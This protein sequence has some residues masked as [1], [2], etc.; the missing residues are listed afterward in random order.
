[1]QKKYDLDELALIRNTWVDVPEEAIP[2]E[3][4][5]LFRKRKA[6]VNLYIDGATIKEIE[7]ITGIP[8]QN[9]SRMIERCCVL[10]KNNQYLGY[11]SLVPHKRIS[12]SDPENNNAMG[13][14]LKLLN[15]HPELKEYIEGLY[16]GNKK[17]TLERNMNAKT[18]HK[19]F[20][21]KCIQIGIPDYEYPFNTQTKGYI[22]LC[23]YLNSLSSEKV[24]ESSHRLTKDEEQKLNS[25]GIGN[26]Y[27]YPSIAPYSMVQ[28]DGHKIDIEYYVEV[29]EIDGSITK[30]VAMRPWLF[31]VIDVSTRCILGYSVSQ[32]ENY[33]QYDVVDAIQNALLPHKKI[34]FFRI[35]ATNYPDNG[36]FPS[37]AYPQLGYALIDNIML[38]NAKCH[39]AANTVNRLT[40]RLGIT[41]NFGSVATP[42]T[43]G[44]I[45]RFFGTL[46]T[47]GFHRLP[48]T[49]GSSPRDPKRRNAEEKCLRYDMTYEDICEL[50]ELL[51]AEYNNMPHTSLNNLTPLECLRRRI[52]DNGIVPVLA[53][54]RMRTAIDKLNYI[55]DTRIVCGGKSGKRPYIQYK[56]AIYRNDLLSATNN[57]LGQKIH[58]EINPRDI[59]TIDAYA[60]DGTYLGELQAVGEFGTKRHSLKTRMEALK[61]TR[62]RGYENTIFT[63][64]ISIYE[65]ELSERASKGKSRRAATKQDQVRREQGKPKPSEEPAKPA[66]IVPITVDTSKTLPTREEIDELMKLSPDERVYALFP[67]L[68]GGGRN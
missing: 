36:G 12:F 29:E 32:R 65:Q 56:G 33:D 28:V 50:I 62:E 14:F 61:V 15:I 46:E 47:R 67:S 10:D 44:I 55:T 38:D 3:Y 54:G 27:T 18:I 58:L 60:S 5:E 1:M 26:R 20:L 21:D 13:V 4:R 25:T 49:T 6:A 31:A 11:Q 24:R 45:E 23:K 43:R 40:E 34:T 37:A 7:K 16:F 35:K 66:E 30:V 2:A 48:M 53:E 68:G 17:Y 41:M 42:E 22:T 19:S 8:S 51:I 52:F 59:S 9:M 57:Y 39:L 64:P 63:S